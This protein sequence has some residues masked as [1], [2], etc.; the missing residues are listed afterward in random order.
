[1]DIK[2]KQ[3]VFYLT[4]KIDKFNYKHDYTYNLKDN[5]SEIPQGEAS[6]NGAIYELYDEEGKLKDTI[7]TGKKNKIENIPLGKYILKEKTASKGY[8]LDTNEYNIEITKDNLNVEL[9]VYEEVIK[10]KVEIFKVLASNT[11]GELKPEKN[12]TFEIYNK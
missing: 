12:I 2:I 3:D 9:I 8:L 10:R 6:L 7:I 5:N 1:M 4:K 11:T